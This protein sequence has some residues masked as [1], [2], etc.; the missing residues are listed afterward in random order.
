MAGTVAF[1]GDVVDVDTSDLSVTI[2][3]GDAGILSIYATNDDGDPLDFTNTRAFFTVKE[4]YEDEEPLIQKEFMLSLSP[5][6]WMFLEF[7]HDD[8]ADLFG[9]YIY[10][11]RAIDTIE[12]IEITHV[13][14]RFTVNKQVY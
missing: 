13:R 2:Y 9:Q 7:E 1:Y 5:A 12:D 4:K 6:G 8:T 10:D 11:I 3:R 14:S